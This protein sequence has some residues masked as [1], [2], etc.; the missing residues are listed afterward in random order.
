MNIPKDNAMLVD[1]QYVKPNKAKGLPDYLYIIWKDLRDGQKHLQIIPE[2]PMEIYFEKQE[3]RD[4]TYNKNHQY[5]DKLDTKVVKYKDIIYAIAEDM[6]ES[7]KQ[8]LRECFETR[9]YE[10]IQD[11][12]LYPY[13]FGAD[14]DIRAYYRH[15]WK[16]EFTNDK[17]KPI[18]KAFMDIEVDIMETG[19][20]NA[21]YNP[22]DLITFI[23]NETS[24]SYT[25]G[26]IGVTCP[27]KDESKMSPKELQAYKEKQDMYQ[28]RLDEQN[29]YSN[30]IDE[31][32]KAAH[33]LFD[34]SY[35]GM[36][37]KFYFYKDERMMLTHL[38]ELINSLKRDFLEVWNIS[39]DIPFI[40]ERLKTF[41]LDPA[42]VICNKEFPSKQ[43]YF[44]KD[45]FNFEIKNKSDFF[46]VSSFT[47]Y[48]DQMINYAAIRKG[49]SELRSNKLTAIAEKEIGDEKL[50][51]SEDATIKTL[52][53]RNYLL[54][55]LYNIKDVLLQKGIEEKTTDLQSYYIGSYE[56]LTPYENEFKQT[57]MLRNVQLE[58]FYEQG[59][60][61]GNNINSILNSHLKQQQVDNDDEEDD[62]DDV[63]FEGALVGNPKLIG[64]FGRELFGHRTNSIFDWSVDF[65]MSAFYP[66]TI[67]A[68]NIDPSTLIFKVIMYASQ[69]K[70]RGGNLEYK[71]IT[72]VQLVKENKD[73]FTDDIAKEV[74]DNFQTGNILSFGYKWLNLPSINKVYKAC[75]KAHKGK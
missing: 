72:N 75:K 24:T 26:L 54:Y 29:Y 57:V 25:F 17:P 19:T 21:F 42:E 50:D 31:I 35:P 74:I 8:K 71:G 62:S 9:N 49:K 53:Y 13:S 48:T 27:E 66:S 64:K 44:K 2:P 10:A 12:F 52:S 43:C 45:N 39:F 30:H 11:L 61:P 68:N 60:I 16:R 33:D 6:G 46:K 7:G 38:F 37:Y 67:R 23:D 28:H 32:E 51:Y 41:G 47:V 14:Y 34:E 73:S 56:N 40:I 15:K 20:P 1:I 22:I 70:P 18:T 4:H 5:L 69:F 3:F 55:I 36:E 65:D 63:G 59:I 58:A